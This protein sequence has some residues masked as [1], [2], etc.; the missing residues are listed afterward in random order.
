LGFFLFG[1][2][3]SRLFPVKETP[4]FPDLLLA[5]AHPE[6]KMGMKQ[7]PTQKRAISNKIIDINWLCGNA[8]VRV[9]FDL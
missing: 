7:S 9:D 6:L 8:G 2:L 5:R 3:D 1:L 4:L